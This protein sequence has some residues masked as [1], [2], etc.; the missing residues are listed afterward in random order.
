MCQKALKDYMRWEDRPAYEALR[1]RCR[2]TFE[3][4]EKFFIVNEERNLK[5]K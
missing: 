5:I 2:N 1:K 4:I 3:A